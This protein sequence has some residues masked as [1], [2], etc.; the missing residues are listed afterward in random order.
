M[1]KGQQRRVDRGLKVT[2]APPFTE[3]FIAA[4]G[5]QI[6]WDFASL[7]CRHCWQPW[8]KHG[9]GPFGPLVDEPAVHRFDAA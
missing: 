6:A 9:H 7:L 5:D 2:T 1:I 8:W 4:F 3:A